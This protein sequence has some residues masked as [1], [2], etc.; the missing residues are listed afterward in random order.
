MSPTRSSAAPIRSR[1]VR[2]LVVHPGAF[3]LPELGEELGRYTQARLAERGVE[4]LLNTRVTGTNGSRTM[5]SNGMQIDARTVVWT[6]GIS[7]NPILDGIPCQRSHGRLVVN[8]YLQSPDR[9][10]VWAVGDCASITDQSTGQTYPP[11]AQHALREGACVARNII[12]ELNG[13][14]K[15]AFS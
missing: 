9:P 11:T 4:V 14:P 10:N 5:L 3:L 2:V 8:E 7:A 15:A 12:A 13:N 1:D 6:A